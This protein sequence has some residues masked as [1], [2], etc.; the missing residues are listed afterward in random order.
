MHDCRRVTALADILESC[1]EDCALVFTGDSYE[2]QGPKRFCVAP[3]K[4]EDMHRLLYDVL[5]AEPRTCRGIIYLWGLDCATTPDVTAT[6]LLESQA[7]S[8]DGVLHLIQSLVPRESKNAPRLWLVT[9]R[10]Q[11]ASRGM[12]FPSRWDKLP[13]GVW[14]GLLPWSIRTCGAGWWICLGSRISNRPRLS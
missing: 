12:L 8:C 13:C 1:G 11:A 9:E 7:V 2:N 14:A 10:A 5:D 6:S 4:S 3:G